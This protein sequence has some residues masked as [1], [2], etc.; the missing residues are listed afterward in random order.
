M[1]LYIKLIGFMREL[2]E[3][4]LITLTIIYNKESIALWDLCSCHGNNSFGVIICGPKG[5]Y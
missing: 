3:K 5:N 1:V 4:K 2:F